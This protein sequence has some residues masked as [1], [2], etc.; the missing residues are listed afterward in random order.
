MKK[1][2]KRITR[3]R[4]LH[5]EFP[6]PRTHTGIVLGNGVQGLM[7]WGGAPGGWR[8][9]VPPQAQDAAP[10]PGALC[11][12]IAHAGFWDHRGGQAFPAEVNYTALRRLLEAG[13]EANLNKAFNRQPGASGPRIMP[14]QLGGGR[15]DLTFP[16][17]L[18]PREA[19]LELETARLRVLLGNAAGRQ[20][21]ITI[22]H[23]VAENLAWVELPDA[24][25]GRVSARL[26]S[27]WNS[28]PEE[29]AQ[30]GIP[31]PKFYD[32]EREEDVEGQMFVQNLPADEPL[33]V[34]WL[35][36]EN[37]IILATALGHEFPIRFGDTPSPGKIGRAHV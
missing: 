9:P 14:R 3:K 33:A 2:P 11:L 1:T 4:R 10:A 36:R 32:L 22:R 18:V 27:V 25:A 28:L 30:L 19:T 5:W 20:E 24:L 26:I 37:E 21:Q 17:G 7:V 35:A 13:D 8:T 15:L 12:S 34:A 31:P 23:G 29:M 16:D 6:L